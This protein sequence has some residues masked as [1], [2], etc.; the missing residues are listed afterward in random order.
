MYF[1]FFAIYRLYVQGNS[2]KCTEPSSSGSLSI[3]LSKKIFIL[4]LNFITNIHKCKFILK[5]IFDYFYKYHFEN[6]DIDPR[7]EEKS[8]SFTLKYRPLHFSESSCSYETNLNYVKNW[9]LSVW[10]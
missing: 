4:F 6:V 5:N 3:Y 8:S 1:N 9:R 7:F 10:S 2:E